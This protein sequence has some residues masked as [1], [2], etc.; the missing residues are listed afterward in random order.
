MLLMSMRSLLPLCLLLGVL[1]VGETEPDQLPGPCAQLHP[2]GAGLL[3]PVDRGLQAG[4]G[5]QPVLQ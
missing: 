2:G 1:G 5:L 3:R 4:Q